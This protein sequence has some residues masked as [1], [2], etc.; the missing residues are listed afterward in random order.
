MLAD[1]DFLILDGYNVINSWGKLKNL[2]NESLEHARQ[3]LE[4]LMSSYGSF[5]GYKVIIVY[6]GQ[7]IS[8]DVQETVIN[9]TLTVVF[10]TEALTADSYIER[11]V[12]DILRRKKIVYVVTGDYSEQLAILGTGAYRQ[13]VRELTEDY[14]RSR[15]EMLVSHTTPAKSLAR[16]ELAGRI[17]NE[18]LAKLEQLR[19]NTPK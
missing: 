16:N 1:A 2:Q 18:V 8:T 10:T 19:R 4:G 12:Y 5:K 3:E 14:E 15:K 17:D 9:R 7:G 13:S 11:K 6:D